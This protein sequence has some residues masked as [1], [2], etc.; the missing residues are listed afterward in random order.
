MDDIVCVPGCEHTHCKDCLSEYLQWE[1]RYAASLVLDL[2]VSEE[3]LC[4]WQLT[5]LI[6]REKLCHVHCGFVGL[7][8]AVHVS[9]CSLLQTNSAIGWHSYPVYTS[10]PLLTLRLFRPHNC[11]SL[12]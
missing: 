1:I 11:R 9:I 12:V 10:L 8:V 4:G 7:H 3:L 2:L 6:V 5:P